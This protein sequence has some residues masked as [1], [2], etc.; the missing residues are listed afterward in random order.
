MDGENRGDLLYGAKAI[1]LHLDLTEKQTQHLIA[2][3][4]IPTFK[5]GTAICATKSGLAR[6]FVELMG[7]QRQIGDCSGESGNDVSGGPEG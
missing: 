2:K 6:H 4:L 7:P 5:L 1:A 3:A